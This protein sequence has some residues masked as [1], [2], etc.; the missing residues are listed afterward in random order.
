MKGI[1]KC[2]KKLLFIMRKGLR[3]SLW[4]CDDF[5]E[6]FRVGNIKEIIIYVDFIIG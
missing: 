2:I 4:N 6:Y 1:L 5:L 3:I